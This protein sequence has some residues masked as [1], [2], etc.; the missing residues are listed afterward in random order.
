MALHFLLGQ[1]KFGRMVVGK[2][3]GGRKFRLFRLSAD[4][5]HNLTNKLG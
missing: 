1:G 5:Y 3:R 2:R 4:D